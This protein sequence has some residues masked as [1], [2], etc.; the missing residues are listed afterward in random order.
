MGNIWGEIVQNN[1]RN[2]H[3]RHSYDTDNILNATLVT[4][5]IIIFYIF[6]G[7][8]WILASDYFVNLLFTDPNQV[9]RVQS[10]KG[11]LYVIITAVIF[12]FIIHKS[13]R[14]YIELI[15]DLKIT[16]KNLDLSYQ[17]TLELDD[18]LFQL[19]YY[20]LLT[21][22][23]NKVLLEKTITQYIGDHPDDGIV[24][25][26]YFDIDEFSN[27]NEVKGHSVG[28]QLLIQIAKSLS[29]DIEAPNMLARIGGD[30]FVLALF[31]MNQLETFIPQVEHYIDTI[32]KIF[33]LEKDEFF[34]T[35]SVGV[36][37]YPDNGKDYI[38]LLRHADAAQSI[39]KSKGKDQIVI[40][41][42]EMVSIIRQQTELI[43]QLRKAI[44]NQEFSLHYQP[45]IDLKTDQSI[46]VE[47]LIRWQH[48]T[49]G[50]IPPLEFISISEKNGYIKEISE[51]VFKEVAE[52]YETWNV[53][54]KQFRI[55][56]NI[57]AIMLMYDPFIPY[58]NEWINTYHLDSSRIVLEI[59]ESAIIEDI[60]KS[61]HVIHQLKK[62]G[63]IVALDD[64]GTGYSSL[65]YL[66]KLPIDIIKIDRGFISNIKPNTEEFYVL[67][68]MIELAHHLNLLVVAEG[69]ETIEQANMVKK[70]DVD[71]AQGYFFCRPMPQTR[72]VEYLK[73]TDRN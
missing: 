18:K 30:E 7:F 64:F 57:S 13:M 61:I 19:A 8:A 21:G 56:I 41:D 31:S 24:G 26:I 25:F 39:A 65:T 28:D 20:D 4:A 5:K 54:G 71:L 45:I 68:Y 34:V 46:G 63:F 12:Y 23:P 35:Y 6:I 49:K 53:E 15:S 37:L 27:I 62:L 29:Q 73:E 72:V 58:M 60:E 1:N 16:Y 52:Q 66:Q 43:A 59:T 50:F 44:G 14:M 33:I 17:K 48:P 11:I 40:F 32:R 69:I 10:I 51:W 36:A 3:K 42:D 38:T 47:A 2:N 22:L 67:R 9:I 70:Y 55:A